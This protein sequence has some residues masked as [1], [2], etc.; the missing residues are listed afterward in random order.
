MNQNEYFLLHGEG[1]SA[2]LKLSILNTFATHII[3]QEVYHEYKV[4]LTSLILIFLTYIGVLIAVYLNLPDINDKEAIHIKFPSNIEEAKSLG[5]V[6][7][8]YSV[9]YYL[10]VLIG[11]TITYLFLQTFAIPGSIFLSIVAGFLFPFYT[12]LIMQKFHDLAREV[13]KHRDN[14]F[15]YILFLRIT[16]LV[17]N[18]LI[19]ITSP[20]L[21]VDVIPF[22]FG[23]FF[24]VAP[25][26]I[27]A[28]KAG[29]TLQEMTSTADAFS[30]QSIIL[31][32]LISLLCL[33][34]I[35]MKKISKNLK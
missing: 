32:F 6:L 21:E 35:G 28:I 18:W 17:P 26:S 29:K 5:M 23:T 15:I 27:V 33:L 25:P 34:P 11:V 12:A 10:Q 16:P 3:G 8:Q 13:E 2:D 1:G 31:L 14:M 24:G 9:Q 20:I 4:A 19:N 30:Y 7:S 22:W